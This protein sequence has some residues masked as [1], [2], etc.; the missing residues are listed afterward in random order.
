[1]INKM[2]T[3]RKSVRKKI[4]VLAIIQARMN[5]TRLPKKV[6]SKILDKTIIEWIWYRL[7]F[8]K[9]VDVVALSTSVDPSNDILVEHAKKIGL[10]YFRGSENDL[11]SRLYNT[12]LKFKADVL[13]RITG[14]CPVVM[15]QLVD[16]LVK[17]IRRNPKLDVISNVY[18]PTYPD[19]LDIDVIS[20]KTLSRLD[21]DVK[22]P[23]FR[24][25][26]TMSIY[27]HPELFK[28]KNIKSKQDL[29]SVRLTLDY[30]EDYA[31]ISAIIKALHKEGSCFD[32]QDVL[33][34]LAENPNVARLN[35]KWIDK[36]IRG[37][38]RSAAFHNLAATNKKNKNDN[39]RK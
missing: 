5:S 12:A 38:V 20:T 17:E 36:D 27:K 31:L 1:M 13:V 33:T 18:P 14:D 19:G 30:S 7:R 6:L 16:L 8:C 35:G 9:E 25:W 29:S 10:E 15:P 24:E 32:L 34:F 21:R 23:L 39:K 22:D 3:R 26:I 28:I 4:K 2:K 37:K 11:V